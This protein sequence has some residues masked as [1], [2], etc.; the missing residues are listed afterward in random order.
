M[1]ALLLSNAMTTGHAARNYIELVRQVHNSET[2]NRPWS[3]GAN[4]V[5]ESFRDHNKPIREESAPPVKRL[6]RALNRGLQGMPELLADNQGR[7]SGARLYV[8]CPVRVIGIPERKFFIREIFWDYEEARI[9]EIGT[10]IEYVFPWDC[11][12]FPQE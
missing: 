9:H 1:K 6:V 5:L 3:Q 10:H 12:E 11:L 2:P 7:M 8:G 4:E